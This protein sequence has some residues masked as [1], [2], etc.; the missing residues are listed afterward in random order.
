MT[1]LFF[2]LVVIHSMLRAPCRP[3]ITG[4]HATGDVKFL[5][6]TSGLMVCALYL[7]SIYAF[8]RM[9][10]PVWFCFVTLMTLD[11]LCDY[12]EALALKRKVS[13]SLIDYFLKVYV[14]SVLVVTPAALISAL[15]VVCME[16]SIVRCMITGLVSVISTFC[17]VY[18]LGI[19]AES[20]AKLIAY[21][22]GVVINLRS[23]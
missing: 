3:V 21:I 15:P 23:K 18:Y 9:G 19:T 5:N 12:L 7:P 14:K 10:L 22:K 16:Q 8:Y 2:Q 17:C 6:L 13:F 1:V 11:V 4:V 20:R